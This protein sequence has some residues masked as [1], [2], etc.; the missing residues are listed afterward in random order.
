MEDI[1]GESQ[2]LHK[3]LTRETS[4]TRMNVAALHKIHPQKCPSDLHNLKVGK[5]P[6][7][8]L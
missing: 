7:F 1:D 3:I 8:K 5:T 6:D 4:F 2:L